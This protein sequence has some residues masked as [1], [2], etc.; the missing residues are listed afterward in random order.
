MVPF[1]NAYRLYIMRA[2]FI[3]LLSVAISTRGKLGTSSNSL[4]LC[5]KMEWF[6]LI[7]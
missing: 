7:L 3:S 5:A 2:S 4:E 1:L 6:L